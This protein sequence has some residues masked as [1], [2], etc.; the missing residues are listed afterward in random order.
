MSIYNLRSHNR[1][2]YQIFSSL[3][4]KKN[5]QIKIIQIPKTLQSSNLI[6][7]NHS[8]IVDAFN[9][10]NSQKISK[11]HKNSRNKIQKWWFFAKFMKRLLEIISKRIK[12]DE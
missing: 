1:R 9:Y 7:Q 11:S 2:K 4:T 3:T 6:S 8:G 5:S 10:F 12:N